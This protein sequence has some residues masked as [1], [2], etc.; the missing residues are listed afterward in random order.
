MSGSAF[1]T[2]GLAVAAGLAALLACA[3][4][5]SAHDEAAAP[6]LRPDVVR[7]WHEPAVVEPHTQWRGF[8]AFAP[9]SNVTAASYQICQVGKTCFAPPTPADRLGNGTFGFDT[10][11]YT[12]GGRPVDYEAGWR[13]GVKW[14]LTETRDTG[15]ATVEFPGGPDLSSPQ[16]A[17]DAALACSEAHYLSFDMPAASKDASAGAAALAGLAAAVALALP[18]R[19]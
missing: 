11:D 4:S 8:I 3:P 14:F 10:S 15:N 19:R 1:V 9:T 7:A 2:R 16:C 18:R 6:D 17:G 5:A 12:V 13:L